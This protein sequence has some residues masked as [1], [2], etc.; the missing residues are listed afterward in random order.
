M[1][2]G[3]IWTARAAAAL[4]R[5]VAHMTPLL[6]A[7]PMSTRNVARWAVHVLG[8]SGRAVQ[9]RDV[10]GLSAALEQ[11]VLYRACHAQR[12]PPERDRQPRRSQLGL[13][14]CFAHDDTIEFVEAA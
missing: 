11:A 7:V 6:A 12:A 5:F 8:D 14:P 2:E 3:L 4:T 10:A 1:V 13:E 9:H